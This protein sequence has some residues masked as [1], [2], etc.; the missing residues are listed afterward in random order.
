MRKKCIVGIIMGLALLAFTGCGAGDGKAG[1]DESVDLKPVIYLYPE[2]DG[3]EISVSLDY[4]GELIELIPEFNAENTWNVTATK[5]GRITFEGR[6]YDYL[7][8]EGV[9]RFEYDFYTGYCVKGSETAAFLDS[10]LTELGLN[11]AEKSEFLKFWLPDMEKNPYNMISFQDRA[12]KGGAKLSVSP[13][14]E[15]LIR[16]FMAWYPSDHYIKINP[17][18]LDTPSRSGFT[19]VE[20]GGNK[21]R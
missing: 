18:I 10:K 17:Q 15:T 2:N 21:I 4:N 20:W 16:V 9:P 6:E 12:Y 11:E 1:Q 13:E 14:P 5:D 7:F 8:W 19:V 3:E